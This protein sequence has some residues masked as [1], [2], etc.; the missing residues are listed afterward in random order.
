MLILLKETHK[1]NSNRTK[2]KIHQIFQLKIFMTF[3]NSQLFLQFSITLKKIP[4]FFNKYEKWLSTSWFS[5]T[6]YVS[7]SFS[8]T[9]LKSYN[10]PSI[11]FF[12]SITHFITHPKTYNPCPI[13]RF[14]F[15]NPFYNPTENF[16]VIDH[17]H[18]GPRTPSWSW[19]TAG[20]T[21][22]MSFRQQF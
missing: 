1:K 8:I 14:F 3:Q 9:H 5:I 16:W 4:I 10:P 21:E 22:N 20:L 15:Y 18:Y 6:L 7:I 2:F 13:P 12:F 17:P 19:I 11:T